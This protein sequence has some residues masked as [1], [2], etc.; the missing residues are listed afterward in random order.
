MRVTVLVL[1]GVVTE[2]GDEPCVE[3]VVHEVVVVPVPVPG[4]V[5][6]LVDE[7]VPVVLLAVVEEVGV[8]DDC[9]FGFEMPNCVEY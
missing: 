9:G 8:V 6:E 4:V 3:V 5:E 1:V 7:P 2:T